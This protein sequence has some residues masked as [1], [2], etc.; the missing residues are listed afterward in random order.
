MKSDNDILTPFFAAAR[1]PIADGGFTTRVMGKLPQEA[2]AIRFRRINLWLNIAAV[3]ASVALFAY[4]A[5]NALPHPTD[6]TLTPLPDAPA[7]GTSDIPQTLLKMMAQGITSLIAM[8]ENLQV[9]LYIY[10]HRLQEMLPSAT[11][12]AALIAMIL[13]LTALPDR[14]RQSA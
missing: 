10:L 13:I 3:A 1:Q 14:R 4:F 12:V 7:L 6:S 8:G 9:Q 2:G 5:V 11:Q